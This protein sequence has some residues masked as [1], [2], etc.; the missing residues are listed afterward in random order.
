MQLINKTS[1]GEFGQDIFSLRATY[2][3][4]RVPK[5]VNMHWRRFA[6]PTIPVD[7]PKA[8]DEWVRARWL[9]KDELM[10]VIEKTGRFPADSASDKM[11]GSSHGPV[12]LET[13]VRQSHFFEFLSICAP[14]ATFAV[15]LNIILKLWRISRDI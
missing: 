11:E 7:D 2:F 6:V 15:I 3:Q 8:F 9:E 13:E 1:P 12:L 4:G 14:L 5:S 10:D